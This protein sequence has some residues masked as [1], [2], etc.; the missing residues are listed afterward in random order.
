MGTGTTPLWCTLIH[1]NT[2]VLLLIVEYDLAI[3]EDLLFSGHDAREHLDCVIDV[4]E[5]EAPHILFLRAINH[6]KLLNITP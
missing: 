6:I 4:I 3:G 2:I 5:F 1:D